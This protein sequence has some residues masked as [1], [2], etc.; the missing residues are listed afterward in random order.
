[1]KVHGTEEGAPLRQHP[2]RQV[3]RSHVSAEGHQLATHLRDR[4]QHAH[5]HQMKVGVSVGTRTSL[6]E[7]T[8]QVLPAGHGN[9]G[10][11]VAVAYVSAQYM[12]VRGLVK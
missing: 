3:A 10:K 6:W 12:E 9:A 4:V 8:H 7:Y 5:Q 1:M 11:A 2:L